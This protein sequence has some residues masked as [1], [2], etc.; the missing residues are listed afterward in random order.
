MV[1]IGFGIP[2]RFW[3]DFG[4]LCEESGHLW[5]GIGGSGVVFPAQCYRLVVVEVGEGE[6]YC[7][8]IGAL[9]GFGGLEGGFFC[10]GDGFGIGL[11]SCSPG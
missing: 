1:G 10:E 2:V 8:S 7:K 3:W 5:D 6:K 4:G 11:D 9:Q